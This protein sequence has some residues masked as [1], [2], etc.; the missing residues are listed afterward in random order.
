VTTTLEALSKPELAI[1]RGLVRG[2]LTEFELAVE[3]ASRSGCTP[4]HAEALLVQQ[5]QELQKKGLI[6][7]GSLSNSRGQVIMAAALTNHGRK[8]VA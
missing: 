7:A 6:W 3:L 5:L 1:V 8:L 2:P 4:D